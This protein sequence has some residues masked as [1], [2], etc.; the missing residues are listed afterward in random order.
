[1]IKNQTII[2]IGFLQMEKSVLIQKFILAKNLLKL[3]GVGTGTVARF[4]KLKKRKLKI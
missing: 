4:N 1:M 3:A 2:K